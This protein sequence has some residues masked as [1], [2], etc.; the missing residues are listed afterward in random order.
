VRFINALNN[1]NNNIGPVCD[2][3]SVMEF[4]LNRLSPSTLL[5]WFR[6]IERV[7]AKMTVNSL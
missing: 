5:H 3:D 2:R 6:N 7:T 1:N 4:G